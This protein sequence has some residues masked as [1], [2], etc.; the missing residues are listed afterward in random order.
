MKI[1]NAVKLTI[2]LS[3]AISLVLPS[4]LAAQGQDQNYFFSF[5]MAVGSDFE[6]EVKSLEMLKP[7]LQKIGIDMIIDTVDWASLQTAHN[8]DTRTYAEGGFDAY[9]GPLEMDDAPESSADYH[10]KNIPPPGD[11]WVSFNNGVSDSLLEAAKTEMNSTKRL[12]LYYKWQKLILDELPTIG[13][14]QDAGMYLFSDKVSDA[15]IDFAVKE[16]PALSD[17][18]WVLQRVEI[19]GTDTLIYP[20]SFPNYF[21]IPILGWSY[22]AGC[23]LTLTKLDQSLK[24]GPGVIC[25][26]YEWSSDFTSI[27]FHLT[28]DMKWSDG[29]P[30]TSEDV[31]FTYE[32]IM[33][34]ETSAVYQSKLTDDIVSIETPDPLTVVIT[35]KQSDAFFIEALAR[36]AGMEIIPAHTLK[37]IPY[38]Q[39]TSSDYNTQGGLP[40]LGPWTFLEK[41]EG[42]YYKYQR[43]PYYYEKFG[44]PKMQYLIQ[45]QI[46]DRQ[47]ALAALKNGE[48]HFLDT[49][50]YWHPD[51][52]TLKTTAGIKVGVGPRLDLFSLFFNERNP[53]LASKWVRRAIAYATPRDKII[54]QLLSGFGNAT[55]IPYPVGFYARDPSLEPGYYQY[56]I[57]KAKEC[58]TKAGYDYA[59]LAEASAPT[60]YYAYGIGIAIGAAAIGAVA[61]AVLKLRRGKT[62]R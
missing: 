40:S 15:A 33:T 44:Y 36:Y 46:D 38:S 28:P 1:H 7:E 59:W 31:K 6:V 43:N 55:D 42:Q 20:E 54:S 35:L 22:N 58:M 25:Q 49:F 27:T 26:S 50:Y 16:R 13:V 23:F 48:V 39:W 2:V 12:E 9:M 14:Y 18:T 60:P 37:D 29:V 19:P 3:L 4:L 34:P 56:D 11:N 52:A 61:F 41:V 10:S 24:A 57:D 30:F 47:T 45:E 32:A 21:L 51:Y 17:P 8:T 5:H 53:I 62:D